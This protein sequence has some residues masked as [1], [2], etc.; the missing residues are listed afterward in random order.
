[1]GPGTACLERDS[2]CAFNAHDHA[3]GK[4]TGERQRE[5]RDPKAFFARHPRLA[6]WVVLSLGMNI[7]L[8]LTARGKDLSAGQLAWLAVSCVVV[9]GACAW[10]I[11]WE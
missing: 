1:M 4:S 9:A 10:I 3:L 6:T 8:L 2:R 11:G 7:I 5:M